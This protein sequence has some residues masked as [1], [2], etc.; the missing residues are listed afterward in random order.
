VATV[1]VVVAVTV[2]GISLLDDGIDTLL[3]CISVRIV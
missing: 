3:K 2:E 1:T